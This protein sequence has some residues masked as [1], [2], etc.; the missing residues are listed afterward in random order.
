MPGKTPN[1]A[2]EGEASGIGGDWRAVWAE[3][4]SRRNLAKLAYGLAVG[5]AGGWAAEEAG[6]PLAWMLGALFA[7]MAFS[8]AGQPVMV[9]IWL[10]MI[11]MGLIGLFLGE[12]FTADAAAQLSRWPATI[13]MAVA[14]V[15]T[16]AAACYLLFR[17]AARMPR[18]TALLSGL[19][20]GM[21][22]VAI[23]A[24]GLGGDERQVALSQSMRVA[25]VVLLAPAIAFG[26]LGLPAPTAETYAAE[27]PI[28]WA[29]AGLLAAASTV[30]A[31][32]AARMRWPLPY[33]IGP[34]IASAALR[35]PGV[36]EGQLPAWLVELA[37]L[38]CGA[39]IGT[40]FAGVKMGVFAATLGWTFVGTCVLM[41]ISAVFGLA[42]Q[43]LVGV[44]LFAAMLAFAPGGVAE[45][46]LIA[47]AIDA[48][49]GF[50]AT[51]HMA[52]IFAILFA[53]PLIAGR[54]GRWMEGGDK[55]R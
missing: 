18:G 51:H 17:H 6:M 5:A 40:R 3:R 55:R 38:V 4:L 7:C 9:P 27:I 13:L 50:V 24:Q 10:R 29:D 2:A 8:V 28:S 15:P 23:F 46:S 48:D 14:Y 1:M 36:V 44:D 20:G 30:L 42:A 25:F 54:L 33:L 11:F 12:S 21:T 32:G 19:P 45:M 26:L 31:L 41:A 35:F 47:I 43:W 22:A 16:G 34:L 52:R 39:S 49:P 37:L 53:L